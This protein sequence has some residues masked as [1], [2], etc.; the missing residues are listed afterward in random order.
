M[1]R[2]TGTMLN[3]VVQAVVTQ[4]Q[5]QKQLPDDIKETVKALQAA[6]KKSQ[7]ALAAS[8]K[9]K[10]T[11]NKDSAERTRKL[12]E[13]LEEIANGMNQVVAA[14]EPLRAP[15]ARLFHVEDISAVDK[16]AEAAL[17][18]TKDG[19]EQRAQLTPGNG[20]AP[21]GT[22][23]AQTSTGSP[24]MTDLASPTGSGTVP[25]F[26]KGGPGKMKPTGL[27]VEAAAASE[28]L[29]EGEL[30]PGAQGTKRAAEEQAKA[31][32][33][34]PKRIDVK[35]SRSKEAVSAEF[36]AIFRP[37]NTVDGAAVTP[38]TRTRSKK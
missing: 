23:G 13:E 14:I 16:L 10:Y 25:A 17:A 30:S 7:A 22:P 11:A 37:P 2:T 34:P 20:D 3:N 33:S 18:L 19:G 21:A 36:A 4:L 15:M 26:Q 6:A 28:E 24:A 8:L 5:S 1:L 27:A 29:E 9:E 35:P 32:R 12:D 31:K 38:T